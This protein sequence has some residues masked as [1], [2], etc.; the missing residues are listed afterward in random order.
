[1]FD[2]ALAFAVSMLRFRDPY[3]LLYQ[4][5]DDGKG[6]VLS[7][8]PGWWT[9]ANGQTTSENCPATGRCRGLGKKDEVWREE[10]W[11]W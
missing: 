1:M 4:T 7:S 5:V 3:A 8:E 2:V 11:T 9:S 6:R 10:V